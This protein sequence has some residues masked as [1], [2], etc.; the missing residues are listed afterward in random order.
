MFNDILE[1]AQSHDC[2]DIHLVCNDKPIVREMGQIKRLNMSVLTRD[3]IN[4]WL[5][6]ILNDEQMNEFYRGNDVDCSFT[7]ENGNRYRINVYRQR[8]LPGCA[9]RLLRN[10]IPT[11]D[12]LGLPLVLKELS[13]LP[14]GLVLVTGPTGSGKSTTLAAMVNEINS[15]FQKHIITL[16]DPIE[17]IHSPKLSLINQREI[18]N[19]SK[20]FS[21]A[22]RSALREDPDVILVG[23]MRDFETMQLAVT[24]AETGHLVFS[25]LHTTGAP[26]T[27]DRIIDTFP[28]HQ[29]SQIRSQLASSLKGVV[30]QV[31][32]PRIDEDSRIAAH[33]ILVMNEGIANLI[34]ENKNHQIGSSMQLGSR[35]G[36]QLLEAN[37]AQLV[38]QRV[39]S[40]EHG[41]ELSNSESLFNRLVN[42]TF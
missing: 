30:S 34:R 40:K 13:S 33:E 25:T 6:F 9:M 2:S 11:I 8:G 31:L 1:Y 42:N 35:L 20:G 36:S 41:R 28:P 5:R 19:D 4:S 37:L 17:Y 38:K 10:R 15:N 22:L 18:F 24:A 23:E 3:T 32:I 39:I 7:D 26:S 12:Q 27:I 21:Q 29:Q 14:R 16:E